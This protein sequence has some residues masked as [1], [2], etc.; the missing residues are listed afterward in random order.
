MQTALDDFVERGLIHHEAKTNKYDLHPIVRRYAYDRLTASDRTG[1]HERLVNYFEALPKPEKVDKL[2]DLAPVIELYHHMVRAGNLDDAKRIFKD[3][4]DTP[5]YYQFG[6][7]QL[8]I[9]LLNALFLDGEDK[10]PRLKTESDQ[11]QILNDLGAVYSMSGQPRRA[12]PLFEM[13]LTIR[14]KQGKKDS[15]AIVLVNMAQEQLFIGALSAA[16]HNLHR[17]NDLC[18]EI[19]SEVHEAI[20]RMDLGRILSYRCAWQEAEKELIVAEKVLDKYGASQTNFVSVVR[21]Y[22][23]LHFLL[24]ARD[25]PQSATEKL[26]SAI[27]CAK[28]ALELADETTKTQYPHPS[29]YVRAHWL[30]GAAYRANNALTLAEE[31]LSKALNLCRQINMVDHEAD[32]L[33]ELARL[34]YAQGDFKDAQEKAS[35]A[36]TITERSDYVLQ[37]ADVNLFLAQYALEQEKD[38]VKAKQYAEEAKKLADGPPYY[39]KVAY[40]EAERMLENLNDIRSF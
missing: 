29:D 20:G 1:A 17:R 9:E 14:E 6:A 19:A 38:K 30:L 39:Y 33:L 25:N 23:S 18:R 40:E 5:T 2:E 36:L 31:N 24:M 8:Q 13:N 10:P 28:R 4:L 37:G 35:E 21:A 22:C 3:R 32:I 11:A 15:I 34:R 26:K 7:Y 27:Q 12:V 16:E